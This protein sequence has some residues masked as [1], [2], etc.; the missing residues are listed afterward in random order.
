MRILKRRGAS[1]YVLRGGELAP[2]ERGSACGDGRDA[3]AGWRAGHEKSQEALPTAPKDA[4][5][6]KTP[7]LNEAV[8]DATTTKEESGETRSHIRDLVSRPFD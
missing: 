8:V 6:Y 5:E 1:S 2:A 4:A 3:L 7:K